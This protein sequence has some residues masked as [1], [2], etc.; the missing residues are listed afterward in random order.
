[1]IARARWFDCISI[2]GSLTS[3]KWVMIRLPPYTTGLPPIWRVFVY[4]FSF[5]F[6]C[7]R[8]LLTYLLPV[9]M[10]LAPAVWNYSC[11]K[12]ELP[13]TKTPHFQP[14]ALSLSLS[15]TA[16]VSHSK[17]FF[18]SFFMGCHHRAHRSNLDNVEP[19]LG[20]QTTSSS[21]SSSNNG[22]TSNPPLQPKR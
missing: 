15:W 8:M 20:V 19:T 1:M 2:S 22:S 5:L 16:F 11:Q 13:H 17:S 6:Y 10:W 12:H 9:V 18:C 3:A 7:Y 21:P 4:F 14:Y